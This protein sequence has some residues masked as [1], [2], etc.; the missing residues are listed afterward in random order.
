MKEM[1]GEWV[2]KAESDYDQANLS[3]YAAE[4]PIRDGVCFH[5]QQCAEKYLMIKP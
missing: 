3:M 2:E 1:T 4:V 5:C